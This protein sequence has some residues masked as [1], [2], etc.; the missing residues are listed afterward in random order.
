M[1]KREK[2]AV[3]EDEADI[4]EVVQYNLR[5]EG[6][7]VVASRNGE[8]G[9]DRVRKENPDLVLLDLM[10][11]GLDGLE[12]CKRLQADPVTAS[13]PVI[14][15]TAKGEESDVVLGLQLGADDYVTKPFS[16]KELLA[17]VKAVLRR[18]PLREARSSGDRVARDGLM[19]DSVKHLVTV[20]GEPVT[21]TATE[22]R[23]LH[24]LATHPG[25]VFSRDQLLSRAIGD[26]AVVIDRNIDVHVG[27]IR[28][29]LGRCRELIETIRGVGYRF[30][31]LEQG[32]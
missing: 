17:R 29:K 11:P 2:I 12:V 13:I 7:L 30:R 8:E 9:L 31:D 16:P 14:M 18:G 32:E 19:V 3:I 23:L 25:R 24:F 6:Y 27:A 22:M 10:L 1:S 4:L 28:R 5:R 20:D 15:V 26:H 21:M